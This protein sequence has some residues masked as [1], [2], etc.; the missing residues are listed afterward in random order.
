MDERGGDALTLACVADQSATAA[1]LHEALTAL[2][3]NATVARV[4]TEVERVL[5]EPVHCAIIDAAVHG[6]DGIDVLQRLRAGGYAGA[7]VLVIDESR[8]GAVADATSAARLGARWC[9]LAGDDLVPLGA[10]VADALRVHDDGA[11][12]TPSGR[13]LR[14][15]RHTRQLIAAG[16]LAMRLQHSLNNPLAALLAEAQLLELEP[17]EADH[18][19]S[20]QRIIEL[21][22]RVIGV[23]RGL[24]GVGKA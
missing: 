4:D 8:P 2:F 5:P 19:E 16:Q 14:A 3:P 1:A 9:A 17:L 6:E 21:T 15:V 13:A 24:D 12:G 20:V 11:D 23:V 22:R 10:A 18:K 7:A